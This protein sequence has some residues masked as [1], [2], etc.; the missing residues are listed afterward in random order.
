MLLGLWA[1]AVLCATGCPAETRSGQGAATG[2]G[3]PAGVWH[4]A[5]SGE[6]PALLAR[7]Y[8][9]PL[10]DIVE[11]N[12]LERD[13][14]LGAGQVVFIPGGR[15]LPSAGVSA[16]P[17]AS[18]AARPPAGQA[19]Q[20][21]PGKLLWPVPGGT[22]TSRFGLRGRRPHEGIDIA[23]PEGTRV[24]AAAAG[25]VIY[26]GSGVRGYGNL[27]LLRHPGG[28]VT[29]YAH[30]RANLV[31]EKEAV[32]AGQVIAEVGR[33]G[34]ASACHLHFEVRRGESPEDPLVHVTPLR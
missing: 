7:R 13:S 26:A 21:Q 1:F 2:V 5:R 12:G 27:I 31:Q 33:T 29:V 22:V 14:T 11:I 30:N 25:T 32:R 20:G 10:E 6:N 3:P 9:V 19:G 15:P 24:L 8:G 16:A 34:N 17:A 23:A 18:Q 28:L 4:Q